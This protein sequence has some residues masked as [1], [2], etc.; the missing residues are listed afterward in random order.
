MNIPKLLQFYMVFC[1]LLGICVLLA[2][3]IIAP[4]S[5]RLFM[6]SYT[7]VI[8]LILLVVIKGNNGSR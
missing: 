8:A 1:G 6:M 5:D 4:A 2:N 7:H 3:V